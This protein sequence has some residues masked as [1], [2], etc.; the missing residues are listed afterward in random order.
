MEFRIEP[1]ESVRRT[2]P[3]I[4]AL[5]WNLELGVLNLVWNLVLVIWNFALRIPS[6]IHAI[7]QTKPIKENHDN[8]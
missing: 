4:R 3:A 2:A 6:K 1:L 8:H 7:I 5:F